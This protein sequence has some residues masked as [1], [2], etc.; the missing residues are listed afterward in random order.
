MTRN[1]P[2]RVA[3]SGN[4]DWRFVGFRIVQAFR[5]QFVENATVVELNCPP[6]PAAAV[7]ALIKSPVLN[8]SPWHLPKSAHLLICIK[9]VCFCITQ[10]SAPK[11]FFFLNVLTM[12]PSTDVS[13]PFRFE[14][15]WPPFTHWQELKHKKRTQQQWLLRSFS[16]RNTW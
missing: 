7:E 2:L 5:L 11:N 15:E 12:K 14:G 8:L 3:C 4:A 16:A 10:Q 1:W 6:P 13:L 9:P